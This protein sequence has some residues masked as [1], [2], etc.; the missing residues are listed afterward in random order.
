MY[1]AT[2]PLSVMA[3]VGEIILY[4]LS[5]EEVKDPQYNGAT[6]LPAIVTQSWGQ[7]DMV[8]CVVLTPY[9]K[10]EP[11]MSIFHRDSVHHPANC[12]S[13]TVLPTIGSWSLRFIPLQAT[14]FVGTMAPNNVTISPNGFATTVGP[15]V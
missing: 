13:P 15:I 11:R 9:G 10:M 8:N 14:T 2:T 3:T 5:P 1:S 4:H 6:T 7:G 12:T